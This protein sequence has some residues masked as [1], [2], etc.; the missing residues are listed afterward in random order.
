M[1]L[2]KVQKLGRDENTRRLLCYR[3]IVVKKDWKITL[4]LLPSQATDVVS[5][6]SKDVE[7]S[8]R[9]IP[10]CGSF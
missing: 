4:Y 10:I 2:R 9:P 3:K 6:L 5:S 8:F 1:S 7:L